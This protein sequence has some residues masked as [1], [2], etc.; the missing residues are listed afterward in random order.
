MNKVNHLIM[1]IIIVGLLA[2][3]PLMLSAQIQWTTDQQQVQ[4]T[5][6]NFFEALSNRDSIELKNCATPDIILLEYG[7]IW[8]MDTLINKAITSNTAVDFKRTNQLEFVS[9]LVRGKTASA[10]YKLHSIIVRNGQSIHMYWLESVVAVQVKKSWKIN[11]LHS[12]LLKRVW[13]VLWNYLVKLTDLLFWLVW[14]IKL[15]RCW[16]T[17]SV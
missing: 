16:F 6:I 3:L 2:I 9:T 7:S 10:I 5:V 1:K 14:N 15:S 13:N 12:T 11:V 17:K 4:Q 8:N